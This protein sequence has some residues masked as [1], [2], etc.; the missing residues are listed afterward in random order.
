M[1]TFSQRAASMTPMRNQYV[2]PEDISAAILLLVG[3]AGHLVSG[4]TLPVDGGG[5]TP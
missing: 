3:P 2:E 5:V 1:E 4:I